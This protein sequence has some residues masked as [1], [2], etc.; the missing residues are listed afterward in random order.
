MDAFVRAYETLGYSL[1]YDGGLQEGLEKIALYGIRSPDGTVTPTHAAR[2]LR[3]GDWTSKL[4]TLE[5]LRHDTFDDVRGP[6]YGVT[7]C[8]MSRPCPQ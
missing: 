5:D 4:G 7:I 6:V 2:Q 8:F 3:S 1:C